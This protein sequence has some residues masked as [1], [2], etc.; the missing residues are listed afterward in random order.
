MPFVLGVDSSAH[1]TTVELRDAETGELFGEGKSRYDHA[2]VAEQDPLMWWN[3]LV[4][5]RRDAGG[6]LGVNGVAAAAQSPGVVLL[7]GEGQVIRPAVLHADRDVARV[8]DSLVESLGGPE[9]W[10]SATGSVPDSW[11]AIARLAWLRRTEP[12]SFARIAKV[13]S[14]HDW[15]TFRLSR[16]VVTDRG[17][18]STTGFYSPRD[19]EWRTDILGLVDPD[20]S[21]GPCLPRV[22]EASGSAGDREGVTIAAGTGATMALALGLALQPR[23]VVV[24]LEPARVFS[25]RERPTEDV[26]GRVVG[27]ADVTG[28][29]LPVVRASGPAL[30]DAFSGV[31]GVDPSRFDRLAL[32][33][34]PG[35]RGITLLPE[36]S[37][38]PGRP[39]RPGVLTGFD[40]SATP[41]L[42]ARAA[43][44]GVAHRLLDDIDALRQADVPV[45]GRMILV[46]AS[47]SHALSQVLADLSRRPVAVPKGNRVVAGACV[48]A[49][50]AVT[51]APPGEIADAW[52]LDRAR[53]LE[54]D[55]NADAEE[56]RASYRQATADRR[57]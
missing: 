35:A 4:D 27:L 21:W 55:P 22:L 37:A 6:A 13:M 11:P 12:E 44:E 40:S 42:I 33:A 31:L 57:Q 47:R 17:D 50:S 34:P 7:D 49:A 53:E 16:K 41:S 15:L 29:F 8:A 5:A 30:L 56:L 19:G 46:G 25:L 10:I 9:A 23:D 28:R 24:S 43:V 3:A 14:P 32:E 52:R 45:G 51:G 1:A 38:A 39:A 2:D 48:L 54:P 18:A 20:K 26:S 36:E